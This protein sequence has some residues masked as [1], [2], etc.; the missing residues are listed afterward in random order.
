LVGETSLSKAIAMRGAWIAVT[1]AALLASVAAA[2]TLV[3]RGGC[4]DGAPNGLYELR[5]PDGRLRITGAFAKGRRTGTFIFWAANGARIALIPYDDDVMVG[6]VAVWYD[7]ARAKSDPP[8]KSETAYVTGVLHGVKRSWHPN[9]KPRTE[10]RYERGDLVEARAWTQRGA[11]LSGA[12]A[13]A[14]AGRD[15]ATD[16]RFYATLETTIAD[17]LPR[18]E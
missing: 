4:R 13:R 18:C 6:T 16:E 10:L 3:V 1:A 15:V 9:G 12:E 17:N 7:P 11:P 2:E 5:M 14:V 8:H